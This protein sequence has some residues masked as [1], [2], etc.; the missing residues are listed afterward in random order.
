MVKVAVIGGGIHGLTASISLASNGFEVII[1]EK[2]DGLFKGTSGST[3]NRAHLGYHYPRSI[4]TTRE[5][6][7]GLEY[8]KQKYNNA[9]YYPEEAYYLIEKE[10][11]KTSTHKF[12]EFCESACLPYKN[13]FPSSCEINKYL[14]DDC[15]KVPE[16]IFDIRVLSYLLEEEARKLNIKILKNSEIIDSERLSDGKY[17]LKF[18]NNGKSESI[19]SDLI[20]NATYAYSNNI[21]K[22][23]GLEKYMT[24][25]FLQT[26]EVVVARS[27]KQLPALTIM[28]GKFIS[29]MPLAGKDN[30]NLILVYDVINSVVDESLGY[31]FDDSKKFP[32]NFSK[33][34]KHGEKYFPFMNDLEYVKSLWGSRPI[35]YETDGDARITRI[36]SYENAPG[37]YS[38]LEGKFISSPL[39]ANKLVIKIKKDGY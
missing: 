6:R 38:I 3:H 1:I 29:L 5:C 25:Y 31:F 10:N 37:I 24:K 7:E 4:E 39:I 34:I 33:M 30:K 26:T 32:S 27:K 8:F 36:L 9:L 11:S 14:F 22:I 16:P 15:F 28:D 18:L 2:K 21:L 19:A 13:L 23:L 20:I 35:P 12:K 17:K